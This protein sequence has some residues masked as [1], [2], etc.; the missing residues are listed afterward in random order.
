MDE[1]KIIDIY[2]RVNLRKLKACVEIHGTDGYTYPT[3][4]T[5]EAI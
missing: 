2:R 1:L 4:I 3:T 5:L